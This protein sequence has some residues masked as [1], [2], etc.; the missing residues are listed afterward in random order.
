MKKNLFLQITLA[1]VVLCAAIFLF[2]Y[3]NREGKQDKIFEQA[4]EEVDFGGEMLAYQNLSGTTA[5][6]EML[7]PKIVENMIAKN[8]KLTPEQIEITKG[9][10]ANLLKLLDIRSFQAVAASSNQVDKNIFVY[11]SSLVIS[12]ETTSIL[13]NKSAENR[14][15]KLYALPADT[16]IAFALQT[17]F[18]AIWQQIKKQMNDRN[19][20]WQNI[21]DLK[22]QNIDIDAVLNS[23][24][25]EMS[26]VIAG[27]PDR[28][29]FKAE[30]PDRT[31][32]V[33]NLLQQFLPAAPG[34][35]KTE[36]PIAANLTVNIMYKTGKVCFVSGN[37]QSGN[38]KALKANAKL[39]S[40]LKYL[41]EEGTGYIL[42]NI[43]QSD[44]DIAHLLL[45][46]YQP[47]LRKTVNLSPFAFIGIDRKFAHG[48]AGT[49]VSDFSIPQLQSGM[50]MMMM[51][52]M[53][54][55]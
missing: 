44:I 34:S 46:I 24:Q 35:N 48:T 4:T 2:V 22:Q 14:P 49:I 18:A 52:I 51:N 39:A 23:L 16:K 38:G 40:M 15:L 26:L 37:Y 47:E 32:A 20:V 31:G 30:L 11:K 50:P 1:V 42:M 43:Q 5:L 17:D 28:L 7:F 3:A 36:I 55:Q 54:N 19:P 12:P 45:S 21:Q 25:G 10:S 41:P 13:V 9:I 6:M 29:R 33:A 53:F 8:E 27:T